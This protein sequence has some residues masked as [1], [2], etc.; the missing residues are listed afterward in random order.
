VE[1]LLKIH[2]IVQRPPSFIDFRLCNSLTS[3]ADHFAVDLLSPLPV[4]FTLSF[5]SSVYLLVVW[6]MVYVMGENQPLRHHPTLARSK[7]N[8]FNFINSD[9][10]IHIDKNASAVLML[11]QWKW[12]QVNSHNSLILMRPNLINKHEVLRRCMVRYSGYSSIT[13]F[14]TFQLYYITE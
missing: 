8:L 7:C 3:S 9:P 6:S 2:K 10:V 11:C 1:N 12:I 14:L 5:P 13:Y 4:V